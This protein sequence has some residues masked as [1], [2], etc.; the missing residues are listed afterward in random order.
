M[1]RRIYVT[2]HQGQADHSVYFT[3]QEGLQ[4]NAELLHGCSLTNQEG[5]ADIMVYVTHQEGQASIV[6]TRKNFP[7]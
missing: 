4:R 3:D 1:V 5:Q 6:I 7:Q 2:Q